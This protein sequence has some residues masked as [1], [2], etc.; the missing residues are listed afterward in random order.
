MRGVMKIGNRPKRFRDIARTNWPAI[1]SFIAGVV[2]IAVGLE[3]FL[4]PNRLVAGG[5]QGISIMLSHVTEMRL[6]LFLFLLNVPFSVSCQARQRETFRLHPYGCA[7]RNGGGYAA[8]RSDPGTHGAFACRFLA[9]GPCSRLRSGI[10][11]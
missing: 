1:L 11:P 9:G 3:L 10:H 5:A 8:A 4:K 6:G 7:Q 2:L